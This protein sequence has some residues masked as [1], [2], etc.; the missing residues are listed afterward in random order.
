MLFE[1]LV[2]VKACL[3]NSCCSKSM[4]STF[5]IKSLLI[6]SYVMDLS[7]PSLFFTTS[8]AIMGLYM[9]PRRLEKNICSMSCCLFINLFRNIVFYIFSLTFCLSFSRVS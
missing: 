6:C 1:I 2:V 3:Q 9:S 7:L 8:I 4:S 5:L